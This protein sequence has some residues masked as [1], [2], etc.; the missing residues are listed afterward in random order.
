MSLD[1][2]M[3]R[4]SLKWTFA[5]LAVALLLLW[6]YLQWSGGAFAAVGAVGV[7]VLT[8][9]HAFS[10]TQAEAR[11]AALDEFAR[12]A[13]SLHQRIEGV[14]SHL[15]GLKN[16]WEKRFKLSESLGADVTRLETSLNETVAAER[17]ARAAAIEDALKGETAGRIEALENELAE[18]QALVKEIRLDAVRSALDDTKKRVGELFATTTELGETL[19]NEKREREEAI[20]EALE[21]EGDLRAKAIQTATSELLD[22]LEAERQERAQTFE[23]A[24]QSFGTAAAGD[25]GETED[26]D[27]VAVPPEGEFAPI[28]AD[29]AETPEDAE[30]RDVGLDAEARAE[31][32]EEAV[33]V[34]V[35]EESAGAPVATEEPKP[36]SK[37]KGR[38][39]KHRG[40]G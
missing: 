13:G 31:G 1:K 23:R 16:E 29:D 19:R 30:L 17:E 36:D 24:V 25:D 21:T 2:H 32:G 3:S 37:P 18:V 10:R 39:G 12:A 11:N 9:L 40:K 7:L 6:W 38:K 27:G 8:V 26:A 5:G 20:E 4:M 33:A 15:A 28:A 34:S 22:A 14:E 35:A